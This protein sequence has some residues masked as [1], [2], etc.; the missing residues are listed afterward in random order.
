MSP[1]GSTVPVLPPEFGP[2]RIIR[3]LGKGGMGAV[4]LARDTRL[5]RDVALKVCTVA[6]NAQAMERFR[7]EARAAAGLSHAN[8]CPVYEFD[9]R[10]GIA[11]ITMAYI[12]GPTLNAWV[13]Q[14]G[15]LS[16]REAAVLVAKLALAMKAAHEQGVIHRDLKPQNVAINKKGEPVILDF[17]LAKFT[18]EGAP[19][20]TKYG[21]I[22]G[23][24]SYMAPEQV[25]GDTAAIGPACDIYSLGIILYE[26]L[27]GA[28]PFD[29]PPMAVLARILN[30]PPPPPRERRPD[31]DERLNTICL[32]ALAK[33]P[34]DR[35]PSMGEF[36]VALRDATRNTPRTAVAPPPVPQQ[37]MVPT[38]GPSATTTPGTRTLPPPAPK[39]T[40]LSRRITAQ[41]GRQKT[42]A[43]RTGMGGELWA[44]LA[45]VVAMSGLLIAVIVYVV[46]RHGGSS[47][48]GD[49]NRE[50]KEQE[51]VASRRETKDP[52]KVVD[53]EPAPP[54]RQV[55]VPPAPAKDPPPKNDD[56]PKEPKKPDAV[57]EPKKPEPEPEP[58][59]PDAVQEPKKPEPAPEP[60]PADV[61]KDPK[62]A[63]DGETELSKQALVGVWEVVRTEPNVRVP[64][65]TVVS[66]EFTKGGDYRFR[67]RVESA[68]AESTGVYAVERNTVYITKVDAARQATTT[69][70][71]IVKLTATELVLDTEIKGTKSVWYLKRKK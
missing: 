61:P 31:L 35:F 71:K 21:A 22:L 2:Y 19:K 8:L 20:L 52:G 40:T 33:A 53:V 47:D 6:D 50:P 25:S 41:P 57:Q 60:V 37:K 12:E 67:V 38:A 54:E 46:S 48:T 62:K 66:H 1:Q 44:V 58:K 42:P 34:A 28:V 9:V 68:L 26:L 70:A 15:G 10:D 51:K 17:G 24:P 14:R 65:G 32:R 63:A 45:G 55:P 16:A 36:A 23:T 13:A 27:T 11:Y 3:P 18:D 69:A 4:Y 39:T 49:T 64:S 59:K 30:N 5:D 29:G 7:R 43:T 56:P